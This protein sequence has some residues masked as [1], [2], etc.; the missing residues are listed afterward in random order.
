MWEDLVGP[1]SFIK[2]NSFS[3]GDNCILTTGGIDSKYGVIVPAEYTLEVIYQ[4]NGN[5]NYGIGFVQNAPLL[6]GRQSQA[7]WWARQNSDN[8]TYRL[9]Y[10]KAFEINAPH[11]IAI[12]QNSDGA[13]CY[14]NGTFK[15]RNSNVFSDS[16]YQK[17]RN[18]IGTEVMTG[19]I[20]AIRLHKRA[21]TNEE[22]AQNF[23]ID[24]ARFGLTETASVMMLMDET[25]TEV[26]EDDT[27]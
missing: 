8:A 13:R 5:T 6:R 2:T 1:Y 15:N 4:Y 7:S 21:L 24:Q 17:F 27:I 11:S 26:M 10:D 22:I 19:K 23:E 12:T 18:Y 25:D 9:Y 14:Y 20:F 16:N 3:F